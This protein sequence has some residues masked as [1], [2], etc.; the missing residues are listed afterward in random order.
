M[1]MASRDWDDRI[2]DNP[3]KSTWFAWDS[4]GETKDTEV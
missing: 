3:A 2:V 4:K 1:A